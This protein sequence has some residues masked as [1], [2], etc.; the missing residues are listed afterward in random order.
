MAEQLANAKL[1][2]VEGSESDSTSEEE[3]E[4]VDHSLDI[5]DDH[6]ALGETAKTLQRHGPVE[7]ENKLN[8]PTEPSSKTGVRKSIAMQNK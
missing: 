3:E 6:M 5:F 2:V 8:T 7:N 1:G 4:K